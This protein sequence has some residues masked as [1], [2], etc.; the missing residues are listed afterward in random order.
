MEIEFPGQHAP[1]PDGGL[2]VRA[3]VDGRT[4]SCQ[5]TA[6]LLEDIDPTLSYASPTQQFEASRGRLLEVA[7]RKIRSQQITGGVV[8]IYRCDV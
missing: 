7:E 1:A 4:V 8:T 6:E 5:F 2:A 3:L